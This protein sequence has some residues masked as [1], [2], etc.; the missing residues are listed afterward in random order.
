MMLSVRVDEMERHDR[1]SDRSEAQ[2]SAV[3][4][5]RHRSNYGLASS[6]S[7]CFKRPGTE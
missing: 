7:H 2:I 3:G 6:P 4:G 1:S 5:R